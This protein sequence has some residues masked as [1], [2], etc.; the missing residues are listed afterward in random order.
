MELIDSLTNQVKKL[1]DVLQ[2][3]TST[4]IKLNTECNNRRVTNIPM[5]NKPTSC[6]KKKPANISKEVKTQANTSKSSNKKSN[7]STTV[8]NLPNNLISV[9]NTSMCNSV[10]ENCKMTN[11][12][13]TICSLTNLPASSSGLIR[14]NGF[15]NSDLNNNTVDSLNVQDNGF[16][17]LHPNSKYIVESD[18][19]KKCCKSA[20]YTA[21][22]C[23]ILTSLVSVEETFMR[24]CKGN[25]T[26]FSKSLKFKQNKSFIFFKFK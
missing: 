11:S 8:S 18:H 16:S 9:N 13:T 22:V 24:T 26:L 2:D 20:T 4:K 21:F 17:K 3:F 19:L 25:I 14:I 10:P 7:V 23:R 12:V 15:I 1:E 5:I 6:K